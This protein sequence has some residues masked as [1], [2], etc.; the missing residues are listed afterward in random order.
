MAKKRILRGR[1]SFLLGLGTLVGT[2]ALAIASRSQYGN[3][4]QALAN[5]RNFP[6]LGNTPLRNRAAAKGLIYGA[7]TQKYMLSS[8]TAFATRFAQECAMLVT[9]DD[10]KWRAIRP[11][12]HNFDFTRSDWLAEF[13]NTHNMLFRGHTL[14]WHAR[15]PKWFKTTVNRQNAEQ[16]MVN[17]I[18]TVAGHYAGKI[19]S[20]DVVNEAI[21]PKHGRVDSLRN[22][23]WLKFIGPDYIEIAFR[24]AAEADPQALLV[25]NDY[26]LEYDTPKD[27]SRRT[28]VLKLLERLKSRGTPVHA[29]GIQAH[30]WGGETRFSAKKLKTFL[31]DVAS[32]GL[33]I[34]IT[35]LDVID[36]KLPKNINVRD[37]LVAGIY[38]EY[39][40][41][42]LEQPA[43]IAVLTWGLSDRYTWLSDKQP[44]RDDAPVRPLPLD[45]Q[46]KRK[47][48]WNAIAS[49]FDTAPVRKGNMTDI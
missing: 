40:S 4:L 6:V 23:P 18:K 43:V 28:A 49:A 22:T 37:R 12:P 47:L 7:A 29:L 10:L 5:K 48:A 2:G 45:A 9:E 20:W 44:R 31:E 46:M 19:H 35:E 21:F 32:L 41:V 15:L 30:L 39:L 3:P 27:E 13:A 14:V 11:T 34:M 8:N 16:I 26:S 17:H 42:V 38:E 24:V 1:R 36:K 33:K 25:Y